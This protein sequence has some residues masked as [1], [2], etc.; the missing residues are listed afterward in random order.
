MRQRSSV[1]SVST[2]SLAVSSA[3]ARA[4]VAAA[5]LAVVV[6]AG[7]S[8]AASGHGSQTTYL[9]KSL[10]S[11]GGT[12][13]RGN[14]INNLGWIGGYS[15]LTED[16]ARHAALWLYGFKFDLGTLGGPNS[17]VA[18][19]SAMNDEGLIAGVAQT[20]D[21]EPLGQDWSCSAFF[22]EPQNT[23]FICRGVVWEWGVIRPLPVLDGG[24]NS[25]ATAV[26][27]RGEVTGW[28]ENG[29]VDPDCDPQST[30]VLQFR[31]VVWGPDKDQ[32]REMP[33]FG[34][35]TSGTV[36]A[37]NDHGQAVGIS[38]ICDQAVGR[39]SA[40]H[41]VLWENGAVRD[42][43]NAGGPWW[44]TPTAINQHGDIVGF[45]GHPDDPDG[46]LQAFL[47]TKRDG[48][49][50]LGA[51]PG[52]TPEHVHS[53]AYGINERGQVVGLSCDAAFNCRA[54]LWEEGVMKDLTT[55]APDYDGILLQAR[56]INDLGMISGIAFD[57]DSEESVAYVA[58]PRR[59]GHHV[60]SSVAPRRHDA[61]RRIVLPDSV[62]RDILHPLSAGRAK[63]GR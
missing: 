22:P 60:T 25:F 15:N 29:V 55:Q 7:G 23:G 63:L 58:I 2:A 34:D 19:S 31:P 39:H 59:R 3:R 40:K 6:A 47:W 24:H 43:G 10:R 48:M 37:I 38:G 61:A 41:A 16:K 52:Q 45:L 4:V 13:S 18:W 50:P 27:N 33:L 32:M 30:Q 35:D 62:K 17:S 54:F 51:L 12:S 9:V 46:F 57:S 42:L 20:S 44:N 1:R 8:F 11:L 14:S 26:N 28:S 5:A 56:D 53:E 49:Q 36:N 21:P